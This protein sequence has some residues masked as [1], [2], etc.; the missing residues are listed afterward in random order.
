VN[1]SCGSVAQSG[2]EDGERRSGTTRSREDP[3]TETRY[4][5]HV[6]HPSLA[7]GPHASAPGTV[8]ATTQRVT[9]R[10]TQRDTV[11]SPPTASVRA[12]AWEDV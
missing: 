11:P 6:T 9:I 4:V 7:G 12:G 10:A 1:R 8:L 2:D 5:A 3:I